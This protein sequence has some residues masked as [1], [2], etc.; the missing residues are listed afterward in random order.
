MGDMAMSFPMRRIFA[1]ISGN[2]TCPGQ[3]TC[4]YFVIMTRYRD[5]DS[6]IMAMVPELRGIGAGVCLTARG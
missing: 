2:V 3:E 4:E 5:Y 1:S 6:I